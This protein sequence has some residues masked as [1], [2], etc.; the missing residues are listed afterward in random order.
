M[1]TDI[2]DLRIGS[3]HLNL[4]TDEPFVADYPLSSSIFCYVL[5]MRQLYLL[6][7]RVTVIHTSREIRVL[8]CIPPYW[9]GE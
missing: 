8:S 3:C 6:G 7:F 2:N 4:P 1:S 5:P 9:S